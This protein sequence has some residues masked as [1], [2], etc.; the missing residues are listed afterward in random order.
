KVMVRAEIQD[1]AG[2][3]AA[4]QATARDGQAAPSAPADGPALGAPVNNDRH[5]R[6]ANH[7]SRGRAN[8]SNNVSAF[9]GPTGAEWP[10]D[11]LTRQALGSGEPANPPARN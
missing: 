1:R 10:A 8:A 2:N 4:T 9:E 11:Q 5:D 7:H 6:T 3:T